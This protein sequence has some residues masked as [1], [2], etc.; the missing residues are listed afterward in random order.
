MRP[1]E[2][3]R[4]VI[5]RRDPSGAQTALTPQ[6]FNARTRVHEYGGGDYFS[7][8]GGVYFS[9]FSDQRVYR[10]DSGAEPRAITPATDVRYAD[11]CLD[12]ARARLICI[13]EDHRNAAAEASNSI[14]ALDLDGNTE[15]GRGLL[16]GNDFYS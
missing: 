6:P 4:N 3:G 1:T 7:V 5:V 14:V 9:N 10:Q 8:N 16:E 11:Y 15:P 12:E 13:R 2:G